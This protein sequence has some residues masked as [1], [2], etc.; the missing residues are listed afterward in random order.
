LAYRDNPI[1][2]KRKLF[3]R[4]GV[5]SMVVFFSVF[6]FLLGEFLPLFIEHFALTYAGELSLRIFIVST[7]SVVLHLCWEFVKGKKR[8]YIYQ[9]NKGNENKVILLRNHN[10]DFNKNTFSKVS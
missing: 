7:L 2:K 4:V 9:Q 1:V 10:I 6:Q 8:K 5:L 3:Y